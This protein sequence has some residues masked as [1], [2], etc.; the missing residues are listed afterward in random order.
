MANCLLPTEDC[1]LKY[2][3][4]STRS[5]RRSFFSFFTAMRYDLPPISCLLIFRFSLFVFHLQS[6]SF[7]LLF[8]YR[9]KKRLEISLSKGFCPFALDDLEK[10]SRPVFNR[11]RK[12]LQEV[13]FFIPVD[14]DSEFLKTNSV[15]LYLAYTISYSII[16]GP[17]NMPEFN[18]AAS[19]LTYRKNDII[20]CYPNIPAPR[21][22]HEFDHLFTLGFFLNI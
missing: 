16:V 3:A 18:A 11:P 20:R 10:H 19:H 1:L 2:F 7:P 15:F 17:R 14:H 21:T 22:F 12:D 4:R 13:A 5:T 8:L 9:L 6:S